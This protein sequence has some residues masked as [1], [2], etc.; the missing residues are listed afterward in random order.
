MSVLISL[1]FFLLLLLIVFLGLLYT[2]YN[3]L[4]G[5]AQF[6]REAQS[7]IKVGLNKKGQLVDRLLEIAERVAGHEKV[8]QLKVSQDKM[9]STNMASQY[10]QTSAAVAGIS[11]LASDFPELKGQEAYVQL[12]S[13][14]KE[15]EGELQD[16]RQEYNRRCREYNTERTKI[17]TVFVA[18]WMGFAE[19]PYMDFDDADS[20]DT[21]GD[22]RT[23]DGELLE[24]MI[25]NVGSTV[26]TSSQR[27]GKGAS[28]VGRRILEKG[29]QMREGMA[30]TKYYYAGPNRT[31]KGPYSLAEMEAFTEDGT[32]NDETLIVAEGDS[33]WVM[34][35]T[36]QAKR[37]AADADSDE[38]DVPSALPPFPPSATP[39]HAAAPDV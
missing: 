17:P 2:T 5:L 9:D 22:F 11:A 12:M 36:L 37:G 18:R 4:Q 29:Y 32:I 27:L 13:D 16:K 24:Q 15:V 28:R 30:G 38:P 8:V 19:A 31:P 35:G 26:A 3:G 21:I 7:N 33:E 23:D 20:M 39:G 6:V 14:L 1:F 25:A 34:F 10:Q